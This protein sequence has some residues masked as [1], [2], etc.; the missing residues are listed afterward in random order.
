VA[1]APRSASANGRVVLRPAAGCLGGLIPVRTLPLD[2]VASRPTGT[3]MARGKPDGWSGRGETSS[4][5]TPS[6]SL[7]E[8]RLCPV[9]VP[10]KAASARQ[11]M[12]RAS[13]LIASQSNACL[14]GEG[15]ARTRGSPG[16]F[17][18]HDQAKRSRAGCVGIPETPTGSKRAAIRSLGLLAGTFLR[19]AATCGSSRCGGQHQSVTDAAGLAGARMQVHPG[20]P[21]TR[22]RRPRVRSAPRMTSR[23]PPRSTQLRSGLA[24]GRIRRLGRQYDRCHR[25][26]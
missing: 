19:L 22:P 21:A 8:S 25:T 12:R 6:I 24:G 18:S 17:V 15:R 20:R 7:S 4:P 1:G 11:V 5:S 9:S 26:S 3:A 14:A 2:G 10:S 16:G 23:S 13:Q